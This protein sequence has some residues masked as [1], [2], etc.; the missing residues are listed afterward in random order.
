[1]GNPTLK[2][3]QKIF[4]PYVYP[5]KRKIY[6]PNENEFESKDFLNIYMKRRSNK[7][8][9]T[10]SL[11]DLSKLLRLA[12]KPC[13]IDKDNTGTIVLKCASPSAG[14][15]FPID[16]LVGGL[17]EKERDLYYYNVIDNTL[18][19]IDV[20]DDLKNDFFQDV[21]KTLNLGNATLLWFSIQTEKTSSKYMYPE[22]LYWRDAGALL[23][24][25]QITCSYLG[26]SSCPIGYLA[27]D[28]FSTL[29]K[30]EGIISAGGLLVGNLNNT[31]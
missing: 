2:I 8:L 17:F 15:R 24:C 16:I 14:G 4:R 27:E 30:N 11:N 31:I 5:I 13:M 9:G 10:C 29:F 22:S 6:L 19:L 12:L 18:N 1:M 7:N 3:N 21:N 23:Y 28:T 26:I 25:F 20:G